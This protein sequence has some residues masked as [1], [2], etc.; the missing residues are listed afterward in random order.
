MR[1]FIEKRYL[2][3][4]RFNLTVMVVTKPKIKEESKLKSFDLPNKSHKK[5]YFTKMRE[6]KIDSK[7][8][9]F[10]NE[11]VNFI[12][13]DEQGKAQYHSIYHSAIGSPPNGSKI[14]KS[15][16]KTPK[17]KKSEE[18]FEQQA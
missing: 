18:V 13:R 16:F 15:K 8:K 2:K 12:P 11:T 7:N 4:A 14:K 17:K 9:S 1:I 6:S 3:A 10:F 5:S